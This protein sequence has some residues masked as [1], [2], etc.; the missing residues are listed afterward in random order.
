MAWNL[1]LRAV[2]NERFT[3]AA[4]EERWARPDVV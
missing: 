4:A 2:M 1:A 3:D